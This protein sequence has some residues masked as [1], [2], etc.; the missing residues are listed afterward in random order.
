MK[1]KEIEVEQLS[2]ALDFSAK[3]KVS[4]A[5]PQRL[6]LA[7]QMQR[8]FGVAKHGQLSINPDDML[9]VVFRKLAD[10]IYRNG[11]WSTNDML[12]AADQ[13]AHYFPF[14]YQ[15][16]YSD[17]CIKGVEITPSPADIF[18]AS[19]F[20]YNLKINVSYQGK[21]QRYI[22][23]T[24]SQKMLRRA[25][26]VLRINTKD[27]RK[28]LRFVFMSTKRLIGY[29]R[30][31]ADIKRQYMK[32]P[33]LSFPLVALN[34]ILEDLLN[35]R[36]GKIGYRYLFAKNKEGDLSASQ[37]K[38][39][40]GQLFGYRN[41]RDHN[42]VIEF[43]LNY[44][45]NLVNINLQQNYDSDIELRTR[46]T[47]WQTKRN[48]KQSTLHLMK[49]SVLNRMF[50]GL[51]IDNDVNT[52]TFHLFEQEVQR[53]LPLLPTGKRKPVIRLR[54]LGNYKAY[55][56][57][58]PK[59]NNIVLDFRSELQVA[60]FAHA[61]IKS[62]IHEY[63]HYLDYQ[64]GDSQLSLQQNFAKILLD[65]QQAINCVHG[66][67]YVAK[68][69]SYFKTPTEVFAR[70][71]ELYVMHLGLHSSLI[72]DK[73]F[74]QNDTA[75]QVVKPELQEQINSYFDRVFPQLKSQIRNTNISNVA[76]RI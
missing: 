1:N 41:L 38:A 47:A 44:V 50:V 43:L 58:V 11:Q 59:K 10:Y 17:S 52:S 13:L 6:S 26:Q 76:D 4:L 2:L 8:R 55:G 28:N 40:H 51:E 12:H 72:K 45:Q 34:S 62:F 5:S 61:G 29:A 30:L 71:F 21:I 27:E 64:Y 46:A 60:A 65:Y 14:T 25:G 74:Y 16:G 19:V 66:D 48:I 75:Y 67:D 37:Y 35:A 23:L 42:S 56:L 53:V 33:E 7:Q 57:Y 36:Y 68:K 15:Q 70:C 31:F 20:T 73:D 39:K 3:P 54:K 18:N 69:R 63:G 49:Q 32:Q 22:I 24:D 9:Y